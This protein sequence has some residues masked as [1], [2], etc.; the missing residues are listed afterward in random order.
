MNCIQAQA[1]LAA[2]RELK[3][4]EINT[5]E[6]DV[7]L[8]HC[9]S[10]RQVLARYTLIGE[11]VRSS[12]PIELPP[13]MYANLMRTL[14]SEHLRFTQ[15]FAP[16]TIST[17][18]FL[19]PYLQEH[20]QSTSSNDLLAAF[21]T[22]ET[23]PLPIIRTARKRRPHLYMNQFAII[24]LA[25]MF[26]MVLMMS[27]LVSLL[28][29]AHGSPST[30]IS[31]TSAV[32]IQPS[33]VEQVAYTTNTL[34]PDVVSA[35]ADRNS[36]YYT[37]YR[38]GNE[39]AWMLEQLDRKTLVSI[40][41]LATASSGP[42]IVLG[43]SQDWLV[44]L[45]FDTLRPTLRG[46]IHGPHSLV[47]SWSLH[48]LALA[49]QNQGMNAPAAPITLL[50]GSFDK[51]TAPSWVYT[52]VQG[53]WLYQ[54]FLLVATIDENGISHLLR[55]SLGATNHSAPVEIA[56]ASSNHIFTSPTANNDGSQI[57][58]S[59]EWRSDDDTLHSNIWTQQVFDA[60]RASHGRWLSHQVTV[61][62]LFR[63]DGMS[64]RPQVV[65]DALFVLDTAIAADT[66]QSAKSTAATSTP[67]PAPTSSASTPTVARIDT[68]IYN[69][70][71]DESA[72]GTVL[73][74]S[75]DGA[76]STSPPTPLNDTRQASSLQAGTDF[77]L[78]QDDKGYGMYDVNTGNDVNVGS[79]LDNAQFVAINGDTAVWVENATSPNTSNAAKPSVTFKAF[80]WPK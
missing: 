19:K 10:C 17:P 13:D 46:N 76:D 26:L 57:Y 34:Y 24:G 30:A 70:P 72:R 6:L 21:S 11:Q 56:R 51:D 12:P 43:S 35:V 4:D 58:W 16:G 52:P 18:E 47:H 32:L 79:V 55:Y 22:A 9:A 74:L 66:T 63:S 62:Q 61:K 2:Y 50:T 41:L 53:I 20:T 78:W 27:G 15:Q 59:E 29:L 8:E 33:N 39:T 48:Y 5:L 77:V 71:L 65:D 45:Q 67:A 38:D 28:L 36:I 60:P 42:L 69:A 37:A 1:M 54:N 25:A 64:F 68:S 31:R 44:W 23:G 14:A 80:N 40:P 49:S 3:N 75:L 73:M 7:H